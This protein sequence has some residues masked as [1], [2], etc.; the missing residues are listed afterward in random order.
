MEQTAH[1]KVKQKVLHIIKELESELY[2][3][4]SKKVADF[5]YYRLSLQTRML[6]EAMRRLED[7]L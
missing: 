5:D 4:A 1:Q 7:R 3:E 2:I 6:R